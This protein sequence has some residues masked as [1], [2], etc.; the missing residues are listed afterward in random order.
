MT[1]LEAS[2]KSLVKCS[3]FLNR[4]LLGRISGRLP[5]NH[6]ESLEACND[7]KVLSHI[8]DMRELYPEEIIEYSVSDSMPSYVR[9]KKAIDR[10]MLFH[11][12]NATV[13]P[14][15]GAV[16]IDETYLLGQS[17]GSL[18]RILTWARMLHEPLMGR[19]TLSIDGP[20][21]PVA[22]LPYFEWMIEGVPNLMAALEHY[23]DAKL[24]I[25]DNC[26]SYITD[27]VELI[28]KDNGKDRLV[29]ARRPVKLKEVVFVE[30]SS[31]AGFMRPTELAL[32]RQL[33]Q[34]ASHKIATKQPS[35]IYISRSLRPARLMANESELENKLT[36]MGFSIVH[37]EKMS[38]PEQINMFSNAK[39]IV[40]PHGAG[41][42]NMIFAP[43]QVNVVEIFPDVFFNDCC[44]LLSALL[45]NEH[46]IVFCNPKPGTPNGL[47]PVD[48]VLQEIESM[49]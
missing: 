38:M 37:A 43:N 24:L 7:S 13:S 8:K 30:I 2:A 41:L 42:A 23:P 9:R 44:I 33:K 47:I 4:L 45:N 35:K 18:K 25:H 17:I 40:A 27:T 11:I 14:A 12:A 16:W 31:N 6:L 29:R 22:S 5:Y 32:V 36:D 28:L 46:R 15:S 1:L 20:V 48:S 26:P 49:S 10:Q 21:I 3:I 34:V 39:Y 19:T